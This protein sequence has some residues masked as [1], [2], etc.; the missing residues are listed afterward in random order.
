MNSKKKKKL[1]YPGFWIGVAVFVLATAGISQYSYASRQDLVY[2]DHLDTA[3]ATVDG[4]DILLRDV[5]YY[6][7]AEEL[8]LEGQAKIYNP[9]NTFQYWQ[10]RLGQEG[11][12]KNRARELVIDTAVHD[13]I[14]YH[15]AVE[16]EQSLSE[17][18][19][20]R[21]QC[22]RDDLWSDM[23]EEGQGKI[24]ISYEE[25]GIQMEKIA[26][27]Q[28]YQEI[29]GAEHSI[30][31]EDYQ[32]GEEGYEELKLGHEVDIHENVWERIAFGDIVVTHTRNNVKEE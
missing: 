26:L 5:A 23:E 16:A 11:F 18:E 6:I 17:D 10:L 19:L 8:C 9:K 30:F 32:V 29:Y 31:S 13:R 3:V 25:L 20:W 7:I 4:E 2:A 12:L 15:M 21:V 28:K 14:F 24:G 27:A 22:K 1:D